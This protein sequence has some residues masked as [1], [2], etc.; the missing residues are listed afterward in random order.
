MSTILKISYPLPQLSISEHFEISKCG[1]TCCRVCAKMF[2]GTA[3]QDRKMPVPCWR[4]PGSVISETEAF[5]V[6]GDKEVELYMELSAMP[7]SDPC[8]RPCI[9][10][11]CK[12]FC[13]VDPGQDDGACSCCMNKDHL[14]C[15]NCQVNTTISQHAGIDC[16]AYQQWRKD[17][18]TGDAAME[19]LLREGLNDRDG[20]DRFRRCP[21]CHIAYLKDDKCCHVVCETKGGGC[22]R[23]FCFNCAEF[24]SDN[25]PDVY[26]H[27]GRGFRQ[28]T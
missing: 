15:S 1:D 9:E 10:P 16:T 18:D 24:H 4:C 19:Q 22:G 25:G 27:H 8:F 17:N 7:Y 5:S 6:L 11:N 26:A 12:G 14:W 20:A 28:T 23:H 3:L 13:L 21:N 2:I